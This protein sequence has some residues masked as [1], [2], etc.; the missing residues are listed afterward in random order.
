MEDIH[1]ILVNILSNVLWL[2]VGVLLAYVGFWIQ[3]RFPNRRLWQLQDPS[4]LVVCAASSTTTN[5]GVY[6]RPST[7]IGQVRAL[8]VATR[9]LT[10]AYRRQLDIQ[11][12]LL[13]NEPLQERI[14]HDLLLLGGPENN[15]VAG[16]LLDLLANEQPARMIGHMI[17]WRID[18]RG[19]QWVDQGALEYEGHAIN[20][21]VVMD[22]GLI[23]RVDNPF[24][25]R[26][27]TAILFAG[28]HTYGTIAA[29]KFFTEDLHK[30]L[31]K[32]TAHGKKN[33]VVLVSAHIVNGYPTKMNLERSYAW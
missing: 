27:R 10:R 9:S 23:V 3:I 20:R 7:G 4:R 12:I 15:E 17:L 21:K 24:T 2:P 33:L 6:R 25:S 18:Y 28:S 29:A 8:I 16:K 19:D 5:T 30:H 32:L 22:Y 14:E 13:S 1:S 31:G 11:N 26:H